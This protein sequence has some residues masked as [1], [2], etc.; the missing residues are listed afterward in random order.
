[1]TFGTGS[2]AIF[3]PLFVKASENWE[4]FKAIITYNLGTNYPYMAV[5]LRVLVTRAAG[6]AFRRL[7]AG[8]GI[9][10]TSAEHAVVVYSGDS[11]KRVS[12]PGVTFTQWTEQVQEVVDL[13]PQTRSVPPVTAKTK[14]GIDVEVIAFTPLRIA[15]NGQQLELGRSFPY[16]GDA[17]YKAVHTQPVG[18]EDGQEQ[19]WDKLVRQTCERAV[20]DIIA[21]YDLDELRYVP[22]RDPRAEIAARMRDAVREQAKEWGLELIGGG[23]SNLTPPQKVID[24]RIE[25][26]KAHWELKIKTLEAEAEAEERRKLE[27][28]RAEAQMEMILRITQGLDQFPA[29][30]PE[31]WDELVALRLLEAIGQTA[32]DLSQADEP[33]RTVQGLLGSTSSKQPTSGENQ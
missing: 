1:L 26:W 24:Q 30:E 33:V 17:I 25:N 12:P 23:I 9:V 14:D 3:M 16:D 19:G 6:N 11:F 32:S 5:P 15:T 20:R 4:T 18:E 28:A 2:I 7:L 31:R 13:R 21:E 22:G 10:L 27:I 29:L 8:P